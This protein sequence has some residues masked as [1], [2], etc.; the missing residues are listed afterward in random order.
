MENRELKSIPGSIR[1]HLNPKILR[2]SLHIIIYELIFLY[3]ELLILN[4]SNTN[5][6]FRM[7]P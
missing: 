2:S 3:N 7:F 6:S 5:G 1:L 4:L